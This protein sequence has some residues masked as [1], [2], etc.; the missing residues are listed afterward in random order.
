[1]N[2]QGRA[3]PA[4]TH[5]AAAGSGSVTIVNVGGVHASMMDAMSLF[6]IGQDVIGP[7]IRDGILKNAG[8][9]GTKWQAALEMNKRAGGVVPDRG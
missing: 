4:E 9:E 2:V 1:M 7:A 5:A 8:Y 3:I 6:E